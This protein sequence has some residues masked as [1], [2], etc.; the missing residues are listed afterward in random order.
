[1]TKGKIIVIILGN[2]NNPVIVKRLEEKK[3]WGVLAISGPQTSNSKIS[4]LH[5]DGGSGAKINNFNFI[6]MLSIHNTSNI[7]C[8]LDL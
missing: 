4:Y 2:K 1:M 3:P 6:A 7:E 5:L 8:L